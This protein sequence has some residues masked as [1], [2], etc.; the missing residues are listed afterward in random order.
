MCEYDCADVIMCVE[1][2]M[3]VAIL[4]ME[5]TVIMCILCGCDHA[6]DYVFVCDC[7]TLLF[8]HVTAHVTVV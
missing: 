3:C 8:D 7:V 2:L 6:H 1:V 4:C 5:S